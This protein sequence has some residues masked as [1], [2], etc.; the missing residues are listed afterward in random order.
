M[1][2]G[3]ATS[4]PTDSQIEPQPAKSAVQVEQK[5]TVL[6][7][8][9]R[10]RMDDQ[11]LVIERHLGGDASKQGYKT[12]AGKLALIRSVLEHNLIKR[13]QTYELQ[14]LGVVLGDAMV[15]DM[16]MEWIMVEDEFGR[17]PAVR[18]PKT[19]IILYPLT[20]ISK[21]IERGEAVDV[22]ELYDGTMAQVEALRRQRR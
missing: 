17:D 15:Q 2:T 12:A 14:C 13:S 11:R 7:V 22:L 4:G 18:L 20:M 8:A 21:R 1:A 3:C 5:V 9:D 16:S 19:S 10:K 6:T